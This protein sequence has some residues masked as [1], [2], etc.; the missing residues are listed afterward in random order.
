MGNYTGPNRN[1]ICC[2]GENKQ[3]YT[4]FPPLLGFFLTKDLLWA[5]GSRRADL[6]EIHLHSLFLNMT[7]IPHIGEKKTF[8]SRA[9]V[10]GKMWHKISRKSLK[11]HKSSSNPELT[12]I[13]SQCV[14]KENPSM[15]PTRDPA[16]SLGGWW[17][18][19][20]PLPI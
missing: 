9:E 1:R 3:I 5:L 4:S 16:S 15:Y 6:K 14:A 7:R 12:R 8:V 18:H 11:L 17:G 19:M 20:P 13:D 2:R 10:Q